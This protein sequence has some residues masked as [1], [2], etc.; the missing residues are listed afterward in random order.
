MGPEAA[1]FV[2]ELRRVVDGITALAE[3]RQGPDSRT[4]FDG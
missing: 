1:P 4:L 3:E 2:G